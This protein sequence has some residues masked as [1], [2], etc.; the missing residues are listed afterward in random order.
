MLF[1]S[2][3]STARSLTGAINS[4][5][6]AGDIGGQAGAQR[7]PRQFGRQDD[8]AVAERVE[9]Q[10]PFLGIDPQQKMAGEVDPR[11]VEAA[12]AADVQVKDP[13]GHR[14]ALA[15]LAD[16]EDV[17]VVGGFVGDQVAG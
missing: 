3:I 15:P 12:G 5:R 4:S 7:P 16:T 11:H 6:P 1:C 8:A 9:R 14:Q 2:R 10:R 13:Q 17:G